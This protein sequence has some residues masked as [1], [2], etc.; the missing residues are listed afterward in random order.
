MTKLREG[1]LS[2]ESINKTLVRLGQILDLAVEYG[3]LN[4]NPARG[5]SRKARTTKPRRG[6]LEVDQ[7]RAL[8]EAAGQ[9]RAL[10]ATLTFAGLRVWSSPG[11]AGGMST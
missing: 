6:F 3:Y 7:V 1:R 5:K 8:L 4:A 11:S 2:G 10:L 9:H